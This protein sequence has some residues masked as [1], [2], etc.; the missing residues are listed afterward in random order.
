MLLAVWLSFELKVVSILQWTMAIPT[1][2]ALRVPL[3]AKSCYANFFRNRFQTS[4]TFG[5]K[6]F[7]VVF[8]A[9]SFAIHFVVPV[10][11]QLLIA[12]VASEVVRVEV[13][14][15][16]RQKFIA[17]GSRTGGTLRR[18]QIV[19]IIVAVGFAILLAESILAKRHATGHTAEVLR[20][21]SLAEGREDFPC[22]W[23]SALGTF[24]RK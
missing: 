12:M 17:N 24:G 10:L 5:S 13:F 20:M 21:V 1:D 9:V 23:V 2:E 15:H 3:C 18:E 22:D 8:R 14:A 6:Q 7:D 4:P 16:S 19:V 11:T